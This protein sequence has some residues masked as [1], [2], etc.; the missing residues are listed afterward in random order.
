M[1]FSFAMPSWCV[2]VNVMCAVENT[3]ATKWSNEM[4][5][6]HIPGMLFVSVLLLLWLLLFVSVLLLLNNVVK[7]GLYRTMSNLWNIIYSKINHL[8]WWYDGLGVSGPWMSMV[9]RTQITCENIINPSLKLI[10]PVIL[11]I[12]YHWANAYTHYWVR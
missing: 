7:L 8:L 4:E 9:I 10:F 5:A 3:K 6:L 12:L 2:K 11:Y 1:S